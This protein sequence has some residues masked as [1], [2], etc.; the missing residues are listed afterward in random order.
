MHFRFL[1]FALVCAALTTLSA[2]AQQYPPTGGYPPPNGNVQQPPANR[3]DQP[4]D[5]RLPTVE[6]HDGQPNVQ[7]GGMPQPGAQQP[8]EQRPAQPPRLPPGFPLTQEQQAQVDQVLK[9]WEE[10]NRGVK[11]FDSRFKR[12]VYD[13][14]FGQE[15]QARFVELGVLRYAAPDRG[16]FCVDTTDKDGREVPIE[17]GRAEH[18]VCD[19]KS[20]IE[21]S[22][23]KKQ[24][25][26]HKLPPEMQGKAIANSPLPFLFGSE[27][28]MLK[29]RYMIR[30]VAAPPEAPPQS[31]CLEAYPRFQQDA[32]NFHHAQFIVT[33][34]ME[35]W[36]LNLIQPNAK[37]NIVY[38]FY[39]V[40]INDPLPRLFRGDPFRPPTPF[41]WQKIVE[42][43]P[44]AQAGRLPNDG[45]R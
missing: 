16:M 36:A 18:W 1:G 21:L 10:R 37:D 9:Y 44:A 14:V 27:A 17:A 22:Q 33:P 41:G 11:T 43:P 45:R 26:V 42:E 20:I 7:Q 30:L 34:K 23:T 40:V 25:I 31:M 39:D 6:R 13:T 19:G 24:V 35:P 28:V 32:A 29:Q 15:G 8:G 12:W 38:R 3:P 5:P 2:S 4:I